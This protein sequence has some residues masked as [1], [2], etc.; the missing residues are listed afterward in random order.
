MVQYIH[1]TLPVGSGSSGAVI[2][3]RLAE[4]KNAKILLLEAGP[5]GNCLLDIPSLSILLQNTH[6][7]WQYT[8]VPQ[9]NACLGLNENVS[10]RDFLNIICFILSSIWNLK[11]S[12]NA[13]H[14]Y[15]FVFQKSF[16]PFGKIVGGTGMM[17][18]MI[19]V[20]G[21]QEDFDDW[22]KHK[23]GYSFTNDVEPYFKKLERFKLK[24]MF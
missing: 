18:N 12:Y 14:K 1:K 5:I 7:S 11:Y 13:S 17:N 4:D 16:W 19:Y 3:R 21:H 24:S 23:E 6:F 22:F 2:A 8:T 9:K 10:L 15:F 20:R